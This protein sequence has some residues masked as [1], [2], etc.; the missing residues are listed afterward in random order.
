MAII[1]GLQSLNIYY[2]GSFIENNGQLLLPVSF[3]VLE[4]N[5]CHPQNNIFWGD[6]YSFSAVAEQVTINLEA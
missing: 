2:L 5:R 3:S 6:L 4:R 1:Y